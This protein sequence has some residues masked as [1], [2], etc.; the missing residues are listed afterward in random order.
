LAVRKELTN[1]FS[2]LLQA[3]A[4]V[5]FNPKQFDYFLLYEVALTG[6][7]PEGK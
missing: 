3:S 7:F 2:C 6:C 5:R 4:H 1:G